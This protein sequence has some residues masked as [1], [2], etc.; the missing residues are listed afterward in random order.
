M[1]NSSPSNSFSV[2]LKSRFTN[3]ISVLTQQKQKQWKTLKKQKHKPISIFFSNNQTQQ[4]ISK[5]SSSPTIKYNN[6]RETTKSTN[7]SKPKTQLGFC[8][9]WIKPG[10]CWSCWDRI[11]TVRKV[12]LELIGWSVVL[13]HFVLFHISRSPLKLTWVLLELD[14]TWVLLEFVEG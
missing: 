13:S 5:N 1:V 10:F 11:R 3:S 9:D 4:P 2:K 7:P 6:Q 12:L 14:Q 8:S